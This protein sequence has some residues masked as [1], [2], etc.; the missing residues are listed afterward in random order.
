MKRFI[1]IAGYLILAL[2]TVLLFVLSFMGS[3]NQGLIIFAVLEAL[4]LVS[5]VFEYWREW[6]IN[7]TKEKI[8]GIKF[9]KTDFFNFL[10]VVVGALI[11]YTISINLKLGAVMAASM[12]GVIVALV[13]P[14][15][16]APTY[17][18]AFVGMTSALCLPDHLGILLSSVIAG[19]I[20]VAAKASFNGFGG[21]LGT[22]AYASTVATTLLLGRSL[23]SAAVPNWD[24][25]IYIVIYSIVGAV[26]SQIINLRLKKGAVLGSAIVGLIGA[27]LLPTVHAEISAVLATIVICASFAGMSTYERVPNEGYMAIAGFFIGVVFIFAQPYL[28]GGGGKLGT[29][30]F[31]SV[32]AIR[33]MLD[34]VKLLQ[35][36]NKQAQVR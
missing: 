24:V 3:V 15:Y 36:R 18:G 32:I 6:I 20:F 12:V 30:A 22:T 29:I 26:L 7:L 35:D 23:T 25:G 9:G 10:A 4:I 5:L 19:A 28:G 21:K 27:I 17:C 31:G 8:A 16:G 34:L 1:L 11:A 13:L 33:G 2:V 14:A